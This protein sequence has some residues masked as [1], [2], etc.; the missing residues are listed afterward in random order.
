[1]TT[2]AQI[3]ATPAQTNEDITGFLLE[4]KREGRADET[5]RSRIQVLKQIARTC[6]LNN[7]D[8]VKDFLANSKWS[9]KTKT[10]V[11]DTYGA[12]LRY[13][14]IQWTR[15]RYTNVEKLPF[16]PTE[17]EID[18]LIA[19]C[20]KLTAA[21]LQTLKE[22]GMRIGELTQLTPI[23]LDVQR[24]TINV[25]P[26][27]G[28]NPRILPV[29]DKLIGMILNLTKDSR[30]KYT[31]IF[32]CH[33]DTLRDYL[34]SQRKAA[35]EKLGNPRLA[36][37]SFHTLRHWK[38]TMEYHAFPDM[39]HVKK[40][41]GHKSI[42]STQVYVNLESALFLQTDENFICKVAH[43]EREEAEL[44]EA[45]FQHVNNRAELAFYRKRK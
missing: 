8:K 23:D 11:V 22:T 34:C 7:P 39:M 3:I 21:I 20:G 43:D 25:T 12:Y 14:N 10:K 42:M 31:T 16:I 13:K 27:K 32:Q 26:E 19:S 30:A 9:N 41:L 1:M 5:I 38:G 4:Q 18:V 28:S 45:G 36:K 37:I 15:P 44:I 2:R 40:I 33:K 17:Q 24:K 29:S 6:D 35:A